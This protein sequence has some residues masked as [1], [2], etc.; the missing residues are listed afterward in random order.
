MSDGNDILRSIQDAIDEMK[1]DVDGDIQEVLVS[2]GAFNDM[3]QTMSYQNHVLYTKEGNKKLPF[4]DG[5]ELTV[6][7]VVDDFALYYK[8]G[9]RHVN[10]SRDVI[11]KLGRFRQESYEDL[12]RQEKNVVSTLTLRLEGEETGV[13]DIDL[14][15]LFDDEI[16][17]YS[18][19]DLITMQHVK[20]I[21]GSD[22]LLMDV[23]K[24]STLSMQAMKM[25][26]LGIDRVV[27]N[28]ERDLVEHAATIIHDGGDDIT[29]RF[30]QYETPVGTLSKDECEERYDG[31]IGSVKRFIDETFRSGIRAVRDLRTIGTSSSYDIDAVYDTGDDVEK[32]MFD[33]KETNDD[34]FTV[35]RGMTE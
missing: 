3:S 24:R 31:I 17:T 5:V 12:E 23:K 28:A 9:P 34:M 21:N 27:A 22:H 30:V 15:R 1:K 33:S 26:S 8:D 7:P 29:A 11:E 35:S 4:C 32:K 14:P 6:S 20:I 13:Y 25:S 16:S 2:P 18:V 10:P 19:P